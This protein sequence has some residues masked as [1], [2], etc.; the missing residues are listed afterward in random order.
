MSRFFMFIVIIFTM[1]TVSANAEDSNFSCKWG[2]DTESA[3]MLGL[4]S[5]IAHTTVPELKVKIDEIKDEINNIFKLSL[6]MYTI[7]VCSDENSQDIPF[8]HIRQ[9]FINKITNHRY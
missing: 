8:E 3:R 1:S 4:L 7:I 5:N 2:G 9:T 6:S